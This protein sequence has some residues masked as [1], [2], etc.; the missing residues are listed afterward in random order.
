MLARTEGDLVAGNIPMTAGVTVS[1]LSAN[2]ATAL[3]VLHDACEQ[4][5][6]EFSV[7]DGALNLAESLGVDRTKDFIFRNRGNVEITQLVRWRRRTY[8][9]SHRLWPRQRHKQ[10][11]SYVA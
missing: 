11:P 10:A 3:K 1:G 8:Q 2:H 5:S 9:R 7:W 4:A 6:W